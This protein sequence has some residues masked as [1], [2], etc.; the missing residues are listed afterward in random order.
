MRTIIERSA[1]IGAAL[2]L[3]LFAACG[4]ARPARSAALADDVSVSV[5]K[6]SARFHIARAGREYEV[7]AALD[8]TVATS[9]PPQVDVVGW[10][11]SAVVL[12]DSYASASP[13]MSLCQAGHERFLRIISFGERSAK[14][15]STTKLESCRENIELVEPVALSSDARTLRATW[16][17]PHPQL[18]KTELVVHFDDQGAPSAR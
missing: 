7:S 10:T 11:A 15:A 6:S 16:L 8:E 1:R 4:S 17:E 18:G 3:A 12:A 9:A 14:L 2:C 5:V 13:G